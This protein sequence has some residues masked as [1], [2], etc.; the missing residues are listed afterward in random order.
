MATSMR[1][2]KRNRQAAEDAAGTTAQ[3]SPAS[4]GPIISFIQRSRV[5]VLTSP[6]WLGAIMI[7]LHAL[8]GQSIHAVIDFVTGVPQ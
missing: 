7:G 1:Q 5:I 4:E 3:T 6:L 2:I 8:G